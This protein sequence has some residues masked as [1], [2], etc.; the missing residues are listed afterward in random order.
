MPYSVLTGWFISI[1]AVIRVMVVRVQCV[2]YDQQSMSML[3]NMAILGQETIGSAAVISGTRYGLDR[4]RYG[5]DVHG[6]DCTA[7]HIESMATPMRPLF[8]HVS[9]H[10]SPRLPDPTTSI[11]RYILFPSVYCNHY[12]SFL[13]LP[14]V[15]Y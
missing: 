15:W 1:A 7:M 10:W 11:F 12:I 8:I 14:C 4:T 3:P 6:L 13:M 2:N 9:S 5:L